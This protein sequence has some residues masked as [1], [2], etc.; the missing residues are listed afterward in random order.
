M[1]RASTTIARVRGGLDGTT[2]TLGAAGMAGVLVGVPAGLLSRVVMKVSAL[3]AGPSAEGR[4]TENGNV[5]GA[6]T[7]EGT[8]GLVVFSGLLPAIGGALLYVAVRPWLL[9]LAR[10]RGVGFGLYVL[11][12]GGPIVL[13]PFNIDFIRFGPALLNVVMLCALFVGVG[14]ALAPVTDAV[15][16]RLSS[17]HVGLVVLGL[18]LAGFVGVALTTVA[19]GT[20]SAW[21]G[22]GL[23]MPSEISSILFVL[24][25]AI[26]IAARSLGVSPVSYAALAV[27]L[28]YGVWLTGGA[29]ATILT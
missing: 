26:A 9:P 8:L 13:N 24:S 17:G 21:L 1:T 16:T 12:L 19:I 27:P 25:A 10:W 14:V 2:R 28:V 15:I 23:P 5:V 18:G 29:I 20:L 7:A 22:G 6:F 11:A 4:V 3:A